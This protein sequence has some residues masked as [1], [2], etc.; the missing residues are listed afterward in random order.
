MCTP[1]APTDMNLDG[2]AAM[3]FLAPSFPSGL[4]VK[5]R[6]TNTHGWGELLGGQEPIAMADAVQLQRLRYRAEL[7]RNQP[8]RKQVR[9]HLCVP[10]CQRW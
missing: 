7:E 3:H 2:D 5:R 4:L 6:R 8:L 10:K 1:L 9:V